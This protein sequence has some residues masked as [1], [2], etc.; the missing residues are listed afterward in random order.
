[1]KRVKIEMAKPAAA[2][3]A[4]LAVAVR[5][6]SNHFVGTIGAG[7]GIRLSFENKAHAENIAHCLLQRRIGL[8]VRIGVNI[9]VDL[10]GHVLGI[11]QVTK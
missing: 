5:R 8:E 3:T 6:R 11:E 2:G 4:G 10:Q 1:M 7:E 9:G